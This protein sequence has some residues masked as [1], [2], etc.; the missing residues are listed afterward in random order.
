M[1][2]PDNDRFV[3]SVISLGFALKGLMESRQYEES[4]NAVIK[5][6]LKLKERVQVLARL[7]EHSKEAEE[8]V[9]ARERRI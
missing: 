1:A 9:A 6:F 8:R 5:D 2:N 4:T 7:A 3:L